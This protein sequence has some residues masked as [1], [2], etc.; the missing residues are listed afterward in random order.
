M[1]DLRV[2]CSRGGLAVLIALLAGFASSC[3]SSTTTIMVSILPLSATVT[4]Q[5]TTQFSAS[6]VNATDI[7]VTWQVNGVTGGN[8]TCGTITTNGLYTA[9]AAIPAANAC[10]GPAGSSSAVN[11]CTGSTSTTTTTTT[12]VNTNCVLI[13]AVSNQ[14]TAATGTAAV[15]LSSGVTITITPLGSLTA[16]TAET[17]S[18]VATVAGSTNNKVNWLVNAVQ[19]GNATTG[20]ITFTTTGDGTLANAAVF[21]A[22]TTIPTS[23]TVTIEGQSVADASQFQTA[24]ITIVSAIDPTLTSL[25]PPSIPAGAVGQ[26]IYLSGSSFL[27]TTTVLF[28]GVNLATTTGGSIFAIDGSTLR[29]H[30]P[31]NLLGTTG[32]FTVAAQRQNGDTTA[33]LSINVVPV[34]PTVLAATPSTLSQNSPTTTVVVNGGY[35]TPSTLTEFNGHAAGTGLDATFP[36][37]LQAILNS[38]DLTAAGLFQVAVRNSLATPPRSA[39]DLAIRPIATPVVSNTISGFSRPVALAVNDITGVP[40]VVEQGKNALDLLDTAFTT[41]VSS[42]TVGA[43]PTSVAVDGLRNFALVADNGSSDVAIVDL[44]VPALAGPV[45]PLTPGGGSPFAVGV[46]E[47]HGRSIVVGQ[48]SAAAVV[49]DTSGAPASPPVVLGTVPVAVGAKPQVAVLP[50]LGWAIITPGGAG[51]LTVVDLN[52]L[53][54]VFTA[55]I[56]ATTTGVAVNTETKTLLLADPSSSSGL[57]FNLLDQSVGTLPL[58]PGNIGASANPLTNVGLYVNPGLRQALVLDLSTPAQLA[59]V[60]LGSDPIATALD[61]GSD[62]ALVAD[63]VDGTVTVIDL[64]ATRS[65]AAQPGPQILEVSPPIVFTSPTPVSLL[66]TGAGFTAAS[67]I[68]LNET[69]I[70][71][72]FVNSRELQ[73]AIP[74]NMLNQP[75]RLVV[76]VQNSPTLLSNVFNLLV[77]Q[78]V[79]VGKSPLGVAIDSDRDLALAVNSTDG[80]VSVVDI[81]PVS[82]TFGTVISTITVGHTPSAV[83]VVTR[84]GFAAI[85]NTADSTVSILDLIS[86]PPIVVS[87]VAVGGDP[88]GIGVS[89]SLGTAMVTNTASNSVNLFPLSAGAQNSSGLAVNSMP[90]ASAIAPDL[91]LAVV[92]E[93]AGNSAAILD[94]STGIPIFQNRALNI[95]AP[96]GVDYDPVSQLFLIESSASNTV[97]ALAPTTL[98]STAIRAGVNPTSLVY[99]FQSG[100]LLTLNSSSNTLSVVDFPNS[101]VREVLPISG[102][103]FFALAIHMTLNLA[104]IS[105][106]TNNRI[107]IFPAPL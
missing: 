17:L 2:Q 95:T 52:R 97:T 38:S 39:V 4:L 44:S 85:S 98:L 66:V 16:G 69:P 46:D 82:P 1:R 74:A 90:L 35:Y 96:T 26:D 7:T 73:A 36:R 61:P 30:I 75:L 78:A 101:Q 54:V 41:V 94:V 49:L 19:G 100:T 104:V 59:T 18:F 13:T 88:T 76:D 40:V 103:P 67:Q 11:A 57:L 56:G 107:I 99:N 25:S 60:P 68:R 63:D 92:A 15:T 81:S 29:A 65:R 23:P 34:R 31:F 102:S 9:P 33:A 77:A 42:V 86:N 5:G 8:A 91:N 48:N 51:F 89:Q 32:Q 43:N 3:H 24:T 70:T 80:T 62:K 27:S 28:A 93:S 14:N 64:G 72:T 45:I 21:T 53:T 106:S 50:E 37:G 71:T 6:V 84:V 55:T 47:F 20:T 79:A 58:I 10:V 87:T 83:G 105:D 12:T 22:P